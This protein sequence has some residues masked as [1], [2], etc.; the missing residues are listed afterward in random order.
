MT[1]RQLAFH[2]DKILEKSISKNH[3]NFQ[4]EM[5]VEPG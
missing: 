5:T 3:I 4:K 2:H 1:W